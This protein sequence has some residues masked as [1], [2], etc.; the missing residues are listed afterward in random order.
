MSDHDDLT[1]IFVA[2]GRELVDQAGAALD[3]LQ[4]GE[5][6]AEAFERLFRAIHTMKGSAG[7]MGFVPM[8]E[9]FH[10]AED[11]LE[12]A[13][14]AEG[15]LDA[16]LIDVL[17]GMLDQT[18]AWLDKFGSDE[19]APE[20]DEHVARVLVG[21]LAEQAEAATTPAEPGRAMASSP[22]TQRTLRVQASRID[23]LI[24]AA[25]ELAVLRNRLA[26]LIA[27]AALTA[28]PELAGSL[29]KAQAD[30]ERQAIQLH[31]AATRLRVTPLT[32]LFRRFPRLVRETA[33]RLG[34]EVE[35]TLN[36]GEIE[37]DKTIVD[38]LF[39]PLLHLVRNALDHGLEPPDVRRARGKPLPARL[40]L[41]ARAQGDQALIAVEDDGRG[42]EPALVR[43]AALA[44]GHGDEASLAALSDEAAVQ[45]IFAPGFSTAGQAGDLSGRGVGLDAVR[46][47]V[48]ALGGRVEMATEIGRG[49][50]FTITV[51]L[52]VRLA[53]IMT[54]EAGGEMFGIPLESIVEIVRI[55]PEQLT[56]VRAG[57]AFVWRNQPA[58]LL[59]LADLLRLAGAKGADATDGGEIKAVIVGAGEE[60]AGV[61]V[62]AFGERLEAPLR[63]MTGLLAGAPGIAGATLTGDGR[64]LIVLDLPDLIG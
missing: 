4:H 40:S 8:A 12:A 16:P 61:A 15:G 33:A 50:S 58:P 3:A 55:R 30:L 37:L 42:V 26:P 36:G 48:T 64:V 51:P 20:F 31:G 56:P 22:T 27:A 35:L 9:V 44:R 13:R 34:K 2:E 24:A 54:V 1:E 53:R 62:D 10:A 63:P 18:E 43:Q 32:P 52:T 45:L 11:R 29:A 47:A 5:I 59:S 17:F 39:E 6:D 7:M 14:A 25:D 21:A 19:G 57:R 28:E 49:T 23:G 46:A 60:R 41:S 38:G